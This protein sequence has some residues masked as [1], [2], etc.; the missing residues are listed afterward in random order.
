VGEWVEMDPTLRQPMVDATHLAL[1]EGE[2]G[3]QLELMKVLGQLSVE[4][5][6]EVQ[7]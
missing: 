1:L 5:L 2:I 6:D 3:N 7:P 4:V